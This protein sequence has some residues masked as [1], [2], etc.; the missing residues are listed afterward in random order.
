MEGLQHAHERG[1]CHRD[2]KPENIMI[3]NTYNIKLIDFG[4]GGALAGKL[5]RGYSGSLVGT[6]SYKSPEIIEEK[7]YRAGPIDIFG[8][9]MVLFIMVSGVPPFREANPN[10]D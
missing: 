5:P 10:R 8:M 3:D 2:L 9:G 7:E 6:Q 4:Y 1:F